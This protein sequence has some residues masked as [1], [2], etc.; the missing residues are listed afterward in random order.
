MPVIVPR[1]AR[2]FAPV[3]GVFA[4]EPEDFIVEE[5]LAYEPA[6]AGTHLY[7]WIE[8]RGITTHEAIRR[9]ARFLDL[10]THAFG[11]AGLKDANAVTRQWISVEHVA[12]ER[13]RGWTVNGVSVLDARRHAHKLRVGHVRENKFIIQLRDFDAAAAPRAE[14][15]L[16]LL[17]KRGLPNAYGWQRFGHDGETLRAGLALV[18]GDL[19]Q[20]REVTGRAAEFTDRRIRSLMISAVQSELLNR[21][22][23]ARMDSY[24]CVETGDV[25]FLHKNG[26]AFVVDDAERE[27]P[28]CDAFEISPSGPI[29]G[30]R[31]LEGFGEPRAIEERIFHEFQLTRDSFSHLPL[32]HEAHGARRPLRVPVGN[33]QYSL[34]GNLYQLAFSLPSGSYATRVIEELCGGPKHSGSPVELNDYINNNEDDDHE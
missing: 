24:D 1:A 31:L 5:V 15:I 14:A 12:P 8:K 19:Q 22:L 20:F 3:T 32:G 29:L 6:G 25:A 4:R 10:P 11:L 23:A 18:R 7:C 16:L 2:A 9:I 28:R 27:R 17:Q 26:A 21:V 33:L 13:L 30:T 34:S